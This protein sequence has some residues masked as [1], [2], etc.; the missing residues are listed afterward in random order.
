MQI[1]RTKRLQALFKY[2][3]RDKNDYINLESPEEEKHDVRPSDKGEVAT[4]ENKDEDIEILSEGR[5]PANENQQMSR[6]LKRLP[7][8]LPLKFLLRQKVTLLNLP[9]QGM[10]LLKSLKVKQ[11][12]LRL[13]LLQ[14]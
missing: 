8:C 13:S 7:K 14:S 9:T 12:A 2:S 10:L 6:L 1:R 11:P 3:T 5:E 4:Q